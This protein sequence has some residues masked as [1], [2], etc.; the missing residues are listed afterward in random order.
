MKLNLGCGDQPVRGFTSID[1][2]D[3]LHPEITAD[4]RKLRFAPNSI[5]A[6]YCSHML[7]HLNSVDS[8]ELLKRI[9][10]WLE[11]GGIL[12]LSIPDFEAAVIKYLEGDTSEYIIGIIWGGDA[13]EYH[14]HRC[15]WSRSHIYGILN[16]IGFGII[17]EDFP[18]LVLDWSTAIKD[19]VRLSMNIKCKKEAVA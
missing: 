9:Y 1:I 13:K 4:V 15:G 3:T 10:T 6:V 19:D 12:W 17:D 16:D 14:A 2:D 5:E 8:T 18:P 11:P 7:E